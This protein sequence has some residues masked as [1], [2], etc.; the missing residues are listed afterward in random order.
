VTIELKDVDGGTEMRLV[1][2]GFLTEMSCT[3]H[4]MGWNV[5]LEKMVRLLESN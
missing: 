4:G 1:H 2:E 3:N 5:A